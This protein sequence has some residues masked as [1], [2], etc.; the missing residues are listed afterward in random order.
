MDGHQWVVGGVWTW[1]NQKEGF[2]L[3][4][5]EIERVRTKERAWR[6]IVCHGTMWPFML[7]VGADGVPSVGYVAKGEVWLCKQ[8]GEGGSELLDHMLGE[9]VEEDGACFHVGDDGFPQL[10]K[11]LEG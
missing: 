2:P 9:G 1:A 5:A 3:V 10:F 6:A 8:Y 7:L 4:A 11:L